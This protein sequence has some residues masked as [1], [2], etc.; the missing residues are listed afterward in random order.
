M[1]FGSRLRELRKSKNLKQSDLSTALDMT[2]PTISAYEN[3]T[4]TPDIYTAKKLATYFNVTT[5]FLLGND[6]SDQPTDLKQ[7]IRNQSMTFD[8]KPLSDRDVAVIE[9]FLKTLKSE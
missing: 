1:S 4:R 5:D 8:G 9:S 7:I 6:I 2:V 3:N